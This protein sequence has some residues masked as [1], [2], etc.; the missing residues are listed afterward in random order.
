MMGGTMSRRRIAFVT[1]GSVAVTLIAAA[2]FATAESRPI[3]EIM[4][5]NFAGLQTILSAL[6][7]SN[8][9]AVPGP[10]EAIREH[11]SE[12]TQMVPD[13]AKDQ[14]DQFL[15]YAYSL[16]KHAEDLKSI[17]QT[18]L[19]HQEQAKGA[20]SPVKSQLQEALAA[21]YGGAVTMCVSCHNRF[22]PQ[23]P[24]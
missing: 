21:H 6:I 13:N 14:R 10:A 8:Y 4:G 3:K 1:I 7:V 16:Q 24:Q 11:A 2:Q 15:A 17:S 18:L 12:L 5:E 9:A 20:K 19:E 23:A 22:R